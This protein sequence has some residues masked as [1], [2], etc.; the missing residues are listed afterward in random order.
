MKDF[1]AALSWAPRRRRRATCDIGDFLF[2]VV[3]VVLRTQP[4]KVSPARSPVSSSDM[5]GTHFS[6]RGLSGAL[7]QLERE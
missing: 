4:A 6:R 7:L 2:F 5:A 3:D 1:A